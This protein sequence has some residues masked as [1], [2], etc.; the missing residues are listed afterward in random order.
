MKYLFA[1]LSQWAGENE[2]GL[3]SSQTNDILHTPKN[4]LAATLLPVLQPLVRPGFES[5]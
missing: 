4:I 5:L 1:K 3:L 2:T